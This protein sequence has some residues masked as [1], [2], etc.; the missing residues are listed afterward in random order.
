MDADAELDTALGRYAGITLDHGVLH[1]DGA[2]HS[3]HHAAELDDDSITGALHDTASVNCN[4]WVDQIA[5]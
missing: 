4:S 5:S 1:L 3:I 2:A